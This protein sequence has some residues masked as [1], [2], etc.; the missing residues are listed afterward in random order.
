LEIR[1]QAAF[2][3]WA[4]GGQIKSQQRYV[5]E[6]FGTSQIVTMLLSNSEK[7][8]FIA[9]NAVIALADEDEKNQN[10]LFRDNILGPLLRLL[11]QY[12]QLSHRVLLVL[13]R[14]FGVL[15]IGRSTDDDRDYLFHVSMF[16]ASHWYRIFFC[17]MLWSSIMSSIN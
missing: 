1:E 11:K 15:C 5:A 13:V 4:L 3:L 16:Q 12:Q 10:K 17:R 14:V 9:L 2:S 7:L 8:Q 6:C